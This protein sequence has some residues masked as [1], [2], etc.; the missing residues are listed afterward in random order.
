MYVFS[1]THGHCEEESILTGMVISDTYDK[2]IVRIVACF[3]RINMPVLL[4]AGK[5][6]LMELLL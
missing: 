6:A 5:C 1:A 3:K 2:A 4:I